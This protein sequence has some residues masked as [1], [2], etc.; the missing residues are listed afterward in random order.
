MTLKFLYR[1]TIG[2]IEFPL[3]KKG[4]TSNEPCWT[5]EQAFGSRGVDFSTYT[6]IQE[7]LS[8]RQLN[9]QVWSPGKKQV[10][11]L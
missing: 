3:T 4:K 8:S 1:E 10:P 11:D 2:R 5:K 7:A 6:D 9:I